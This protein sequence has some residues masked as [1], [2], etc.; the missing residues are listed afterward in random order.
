MES[1][2]QFKTLVENVVF[3]TRKTQ[4]QLAQDM[5]YGKNYISD[6]LSPKGKLTQKFIEAFK[7][8]YSPF[9]GTPPLR[10]NS[11]NTNMQPVSDS[12]YISSLEDQVQYLRNRID[13][14]LGKIESNLDRVSED[15]IL[16]RADLRAYG[17]YQVMKDAKGNEKT[18][19]KIMEQ[20]NILIAQNLT[21]FHKADN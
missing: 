18:R 1:K 8:K 11:E 5:G 3:A 12:R 15:V 2:E 6:V 4:E 17:E 10:N 7:R 14:V 19:E 16:G 21:E 20:I 9:L 13:R